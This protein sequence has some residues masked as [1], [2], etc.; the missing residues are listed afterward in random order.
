MMGTQK[1]A[2]VASKR[3]VKKEERHYAPLTRLQRSLLKEIREL[4]SMVGLDIGEIVERTSGVERTTSLRSVRDTV[5][6][7][8]VIESYAMIDALLEIT[9]RRYY[10]G[11][12]PKAIKDF[13][14]SKRVHKF[15]QLLE[16]LSVIQKLRQVKKVVAMPKAV[17]RKI[18]RVNAVRNVLAHSLLPREGRFSWKYKGHDIFSLPGI[19]S[20]RD[21]V[22]VII[23]FL[24]PEVANV[25]PEGTTE[26]HGDRQ[27]IAEPPESFAPLVTQQDSR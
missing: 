26:S 15:N 22:D 16:E 8:Q 7:G 13:G 14:R 25:W 11:T 20:F 9:I 6:R 17:T 23:D 19:S 18:E 27:L 10:F 12:G 24:L 2:S 4:Y 21:D 1:S 3:R 5:V